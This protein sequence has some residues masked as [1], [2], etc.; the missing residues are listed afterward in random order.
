MVLKMQGGAD[1]E[2]AGGVEV[3][4]VTFFDLVAL[5]TRFAEAVDE[6]TALFCCEPARDVGLT[7]G[8]IDCYDVAAIGEV[9]GPNIEGGLQAA[10]C[11]GFSGFEIEL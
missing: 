10:S 2:L 3:A 8:G 6:F 5:E 7:G 4:G 11:E 9:D 1:A